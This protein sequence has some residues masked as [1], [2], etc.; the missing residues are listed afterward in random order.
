MRT[1]I[2]KFFSPVTPM[3]PVFAI[4][5]F[6]LLQTYFASNTFSFA[7]WKSSDNIFGHLLL[8]Y[9]I[10]LAGLILLLSL[11]LAVSLRF[12]RPWIAVTALVI[13]SIPFSWELWVRSL[14]F[15]SSTIR[16]GIRLLLLPVTLLYFRVGL[17]RFRGTACAVLILCALSF[18]GHA[19][20]SIST[21]MSRDFD[22]VDLDRKPNVHVIMMDSFTHSSVTKEFMGVENPGADYLATLDN[23]IHAGTRG[24]VEDVPT[25]NS[26]AALFELEKTYRNYGTFNGSV[27]SLLT[28][29]LRENGYSISTGFSNYYFGLGKGE[30]VDHYHIGGGSQRPKFDLICSSKRGS[31]GFCSSSFSQYVFDRFFAERIKDRRKDWPDNIVDLIDHAEQ[32]AHGPVFSGYEMHNPIGHTPNDYQTDDAGMFSEYKEHFVRQARH[33]REIV[34]KIERLRTSYPQSVFIVS[35]DHGPFLSRTA[36]QENRRFIVLDRHAVALSLLNA[37]NLCPWPRD[38]LSRQRYL[39]PA[40]ML[41][42]SLACDGES[43]KLVEHFT[44]NDEFIRFGDSFGVG[45]AGGG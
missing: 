33:S 10:W 16:R 40:R 8:Y 26:W 37:S 15:D 7:F 9:G 35:G 38:W 14:E 18:V 21:W 20:L 41:A 45:V 29:F 19:G 24:F 3:R 31:L 43:R 44:D 42:A 25:K 28:V 4:G 34:E 23:A 2:V 32:N 12:N 5:L 6:A 27:P 36:P 30:Y 17:E 1:R 13:L 22:T 39:T 11:F